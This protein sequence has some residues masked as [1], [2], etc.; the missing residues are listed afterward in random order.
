MLVVVKGK[1]MASL[2]FTEYVPQGTCFPSND[3][4]MQTT[5][6]LPFSN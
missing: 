4:E 1:L 2:N 3:A 6:F 5:F